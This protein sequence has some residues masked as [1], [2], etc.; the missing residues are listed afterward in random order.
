MVMS[1]IPA[2]LKIHTDINFE[3]GIE[4][5]LKDPLHHATTEAHSD[6]F[7]SN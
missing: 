4:S 7:F 3:K 2:A 1:F 5:P 6:K